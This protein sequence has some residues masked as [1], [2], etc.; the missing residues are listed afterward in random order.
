VCVNS[1]S[2]V[3][4]GAGDNGECKA[5]PGKARSSRVRQGVNERLDGDALFS[6]E[7]PVYSTFSPIILHYVNF[8]FCSSDKVKVDYY[9]TQCFYLKL[10]P[11]KS[12]VKYYCFFAIIFRLQL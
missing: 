12:L 9:D 1:A 5:K 2:T 11:L 6:L 8:L 3:L 7:K 4:R 10:E